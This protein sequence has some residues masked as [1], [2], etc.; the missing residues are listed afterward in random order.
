MTQMQDLSSGDY[1]DNR[2][3]ELQV[4]DCRHFAGLTLHYLNHVVKPINPALKNWYFGVQTTHIRQ[5]N[6]AFV[7]AVHL[8]EDGDGLDLFF[9]DPTVLAERRLKYLTPAKVR[10]LIEATADNDHYFIIK[11]YA[12]DFV[13]RQIDSD[14]AFKEELIRL[15][16]GLGEVDV[17]PLLE[18]GN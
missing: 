13:G 7:K 9:F 17:L 2:G 15:D 6:H 10:R 18:V 8:H 5:Y 4:G 11:R 16:D 3:Q 12:E 14:A 1:F